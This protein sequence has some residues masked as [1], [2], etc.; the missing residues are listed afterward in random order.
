MIGIR[1]VSNPFGFGLSAG[2]DGLEEV[3]ELLVFGRGGYRE[4]DGVCDK[5]DISILASCPEIDVVVRATLLSR[6]IVSFP[7]SPD[8]SQNPTKLE[9]ISLYIH[10]FSAITIWRAVEDP[11]TAQKN[12]LVGREAE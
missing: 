4:F 5:S 1:C 12:K 7:S 11:I 2:V 8:P 3:E 9:C 10:S 6:S